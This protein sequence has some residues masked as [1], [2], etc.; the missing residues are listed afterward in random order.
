MRIWC[1]AL[2]LDRTT[3]DGEGRLSPANRAAIAQA[4]RDGR[5]VVIASGRP[6]AAL[7]PEV[8]SLPGVRFAIVSNGAAVYELPAGRCLIRHRLAGG[9]VDA[10][11]KVIGGPVTAGRAGCEALEDGVPY[12]SAAYYA[13]PAA[14]GATEWGAG[15]IRR[16]RRPQ[17]DILGFIRSRRERLDSVNLML[18]DKEA[19]R[20][21]WARLEAEVPA[22]Y[23]TA[24]SDYFIEISDIHGGKHNALRELLGRL[25]ISPRETAAFGDA[26]NDARML[27][28]VGAGVAVA[29]ATPLCRQAAAYLTDSHDRDGVAKWLR[30]VLPTL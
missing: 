5:E 30:Q 1:I 14:Y 11:L 10:V 15:Y 20:R 18:A 24:S 29:N 12:C 6:F 25:R 9:S 27:A 17:R 22:V 3:L 19:R 28:F 13:D 8:T 4:V 26:D 21:L 2:D 23:L 7:P 16:T